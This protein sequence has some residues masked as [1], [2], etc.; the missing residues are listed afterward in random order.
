[1]TSTSKIVPS[2]VHT[3]CLKGRRLAAQKLKGRRRKDAPLGAFAETLDPALAE[4]ASEED[5]SECVICE[6]LETFAMRGV[7]GNEH[8]VYQ[9]LV[10]SCGQLGYYLVWIVCMEDLPFPILLS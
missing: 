1:M 7:R 5:H 10:W 4:Y 3:G 8:R 2:A 9:C 6:M